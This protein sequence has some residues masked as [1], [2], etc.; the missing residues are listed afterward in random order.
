MG[1]GLRRLARAKA[2]QAVVWVVPGLSLCK[3]AGQTPC[4][5]LIRPLKWLFQ[6]EDSAWACAR[7]H[8][9]YPEF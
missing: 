4:P 5:F 2:A 3:R 6:G 1:L 7:T 8:T 9:H